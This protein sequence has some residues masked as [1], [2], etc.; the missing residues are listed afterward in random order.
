MLKWLMFYPAAQTQATPE[1]PACH[2]EPSSC[3]QERSEESR[4]LRTAQNNAGADRLSRVL[5]LANELNDSRL[6]KKTENRWNAGKRAAQSRNI[7]QTRPWTRSTGPKTGRGKT[8]SALNAYKHGMR[9]AQMAELNRVMRAQSCFVRLLHAEHLLRNTSPSDVFVLIRR[10]V[11]L[12]EIMLKTRKSFEAAGIETAALDARLI[13]RQGGNLSDSDLITA[14]DTPLSP[15]IIENIEKLAIRRL[16][17]EPVSRLAGGREFW[18]LHFKISPDT[19]DPRPD[20]ETLIEAALKW[21]RSYTPQTAIPSEAE[22]SSRPLRILDLGTGSG[23]ILIT[24]LKELPDAT[25]V[26]IDISA[27]ALSIS[28]ENAKSLGV[29]DRAEF[30]QGSWWEGVAEGES[31]DLIVSNPPYIPAA[32]IE[33]LAVE[34]R[35]HDPIQALS[36][37]VDGLDAYKII[38]HDLKKRLVCGG[39]ALFEIGRGQEKDLARLVDESNMYVCDSYR[40]LGGIL[41]VVEISCGEK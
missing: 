40:D 20:T 9:S 32:E 22:G 1:T 13:A 21:A 5:F 28:R 41:R 23:C 12:S 27:G 33:S 18:G 6:R 30:R 19:L 26:G 8:I 31:Y 25:G 37:G 2:P 38:L 14:A 17:G 24:L 34:V 3:H 29:A 35:N 11:T 4:V 39:R 7:R 10:M 36:G 15:Q 16:A